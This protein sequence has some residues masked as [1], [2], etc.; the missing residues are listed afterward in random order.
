VE[1]EVK[2]SLLD[3]VVDVI[4]DMDGDF[5]S[6]INDTDEAAQVAQIV[7]TTY[8]AIMSNRNWP[9]TARV[10]NITPYAD[11]DLPTHCSIEDDVKELISVYYDIRKNSGD[12]LDYKQ[13]KYL[14]P[15]DFLRHTNQRNS[16]DVN[17]TV[18]LDPSGVK[19]I[20]S[21][22][23]APEY[24]TSFDDTTIVFDSYDSDIDSTIQASKTQIRAYVIPPFE[25][26]D[27]FVP[28]LPDEAFILL[29]E[30]AKSKAMFKLHQTQDIKAEQESSRQNRWLSRKSWRA[31]EKDIYPYDY[32][33]GRRGG[34]RKRRDPT[35]RRD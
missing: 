26:V 27:D 14:D 23:K 4:N 20:I 25:L 30:E 13:I 1:C 5:I 29:I 21:T 6:S 17:S 28:D 18:I 2:Y 24:Y 11:S 15:D 22:N 8:Q 16:L 19:L 32:G 7:K 10:L 31:H 12:R 9:H 35:F 34:G 3:I 33:R